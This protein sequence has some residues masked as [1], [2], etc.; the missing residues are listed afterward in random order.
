MQHMHCT[1]LPNAVHDN[2]QLLHSTVEMLLLLD[3]TCCCTGCCAG[4]GL[5]YKDLATAPLVACRQLQAENTYCTYYKCAS[6][7]A[8][9]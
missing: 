8:Y 4:T 9:N 6:A 1:L 5:I 3:P 7:T 2:E